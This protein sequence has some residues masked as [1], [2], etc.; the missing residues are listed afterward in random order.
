MVVVRWFQQEVK[1][2]MGRGAKMEGEREREISIT[3]ADVVGIHSTVCLVLPEGQIDQCISSTITTR[4]LW[5]VPPHAGACMACLTRP[6]ERRM[7]Q[8]HHLE[9]VVY[10]TICPTCLS[11]LCCLNRNQR[12]AMPCR[13]THLDG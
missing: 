6:T 8:Q 1:V 11:Q 2:K 9:A 3:L 12:R 13:K 5:C 4:K 7:Y 10:P